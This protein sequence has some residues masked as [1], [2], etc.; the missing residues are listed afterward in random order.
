MKV[1][2]ERARLCHAREIHSLIRGAADAGQ[3]LPRPL[4]DLYEC[5]RDFV[6]AIDDETG[7]IVGCCAL[8]VIWE[9]LA[10]VRSLAVDEAWRGHGIGRRLVQM[11]L[12][13]AAELVI[14][15]VFALTYVPEFFKK[16]GFEDISK[17]QLPHKVWSDCIKCHKF[18][19]CDEQAVAR[20]IVVPVRNKP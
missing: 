18:P 20:E 9:D 15:R 3:M 14:P 1:R 6:V 19:D 2:Y 13:D 17:D 10:E 12:A 11:C 4:S 8:H 5:V 16:L 7:R